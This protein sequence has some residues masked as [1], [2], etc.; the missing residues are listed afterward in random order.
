MEKVI[1]IAYIVGFIFILILFITSLY[2]KGQIQFLLLKLLFPQKLSK[3]KSYLSFL[4]NI[5]FFSF[6]LATFFWILWPVYY[7]KHKIDTW[8]DEKFLL[9]RKL[10][11]NNHKIY[12]LFILLILWLFGLSYLISK[13]K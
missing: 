12:A 9:H 3:V 13:F 1:D 11:H 5:S 6:D 7:R 4:F 8:D 10:I 2:I